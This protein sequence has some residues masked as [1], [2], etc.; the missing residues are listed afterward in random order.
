MKKKPIFKIKLSCSTCRTY[1][2]T[3][4]K[5]GAGN[6]IKCFKDNISDDKTSGTGFCHS[7]G[8]QF[9]RESKIGNRPILKIIQGRVSIKGRTGKNSSH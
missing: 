1:L 8:K 4:K 5:E 2:F 7:C 6:L 9:A 3:Y